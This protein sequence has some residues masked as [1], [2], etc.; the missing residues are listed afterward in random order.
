MIIDLA[1]DLSHVSSSL[2]LVLFVRW[3]A[4]GRIPFPSQEI[5]HPG[6][7][8]TDPAVLRLCLYA[9][10]HPFT[11]IMILDAVLVSASPCA[12]LLSPISVITPTIKYAVRDR[13][14]FSVLYK[15]K[16]EGY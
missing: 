4:N 8:H 12:S 13:L 9:S 14:E 10:S 5:F 11:I 2:V 3:L 1:K 7:R 16:V 6:Y 15:R